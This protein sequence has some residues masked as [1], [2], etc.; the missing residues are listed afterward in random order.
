M[1]RAWH[2]K[3]SQKKEKEKKKI[4][5]L[6]FLDQNILSLFVSLFTTT[7]LVTQW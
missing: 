3:A 2:K 6:T 7:S 1:Y 4:F 5:F